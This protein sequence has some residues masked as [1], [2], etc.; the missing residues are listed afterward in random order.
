MRNLFFV[1]SK[2]ICIMRGCGNLT[3]HFFFLFLFSHFLTLR[4]RLL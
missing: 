1:G 4:G 3:F 2:N